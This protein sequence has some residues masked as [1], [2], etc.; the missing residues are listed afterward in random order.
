ME[1]KKVTQDN[2]EMMQKVIVS[3]QKIMDKYI[4]KQDEY[5]KKKIKDMENK[6]DDI[7]TNPNY[8]KKTLMAQEKVK[9]ISNYRFIMFVMFG[10]IFFCS[11]YSKT[12]AYI[13]N[14]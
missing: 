14:C 1:N 11:A 12:V 7:K 9:L 10:F 13:C 2:F 4:S 8:V 3:N 5:L 6:Y